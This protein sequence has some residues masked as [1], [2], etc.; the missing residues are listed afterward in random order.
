M[1]RSWRCDCF[2]GIGRVSGSGL[3]CSVCPVEGWRGGSPY[4]VVVCEIEIF[5]SVSETSTSPGHP[6]SAV[7]LPKS[8]P[9][10]HLQRINRQTHH[11]TA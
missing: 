9:Q 7:T 8:N 10:R 2:G 4:F 11:T 3:G 6:S 1:S 5:F